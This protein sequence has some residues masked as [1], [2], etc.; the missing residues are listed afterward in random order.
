MML[1][2]DVDALANLAIDSASEQGVGITKSLL[3]KYFPTV[4]LSVDMAGG[5]KPTTG[6]LISIFSLIDFI[7]S[8]DIFFS[9]APTNE[10][11]KAA[12]DSSISTS[13]FVLVV[14]ILIP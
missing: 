6:I 3:E 4:E 7:S 13:F 10:E 9:S 5:S 1:A 8:G 11:W 12:A 2:G 14:I